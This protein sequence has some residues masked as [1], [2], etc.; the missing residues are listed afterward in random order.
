MFS[1]GFCVFRNF[2]LTRL[3]FDENP[4]FDSIDFR[5]HQKVNCTMS[6]GFWVERILSMHPSEFLRRKA[7]K[8][9]TIEHEKPTLTVDKN[10]NL[11]P[12]QGHMKI[13]SLLFCINE[14][15]LYF[16]VVD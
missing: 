12:C 8:T 3:L 5:P 7:L 9:L 6:I 14:K 16:F 13:P 2:D 4:N 15:F 1:N 10:S 11:D